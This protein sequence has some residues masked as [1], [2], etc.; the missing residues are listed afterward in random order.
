MLNAIE[1]SRAT[2]K[3]EQ[4][5]QD[6]RP[7]ARVVV[8]GAN[9]ERDRRAYAGLTGTLVRPARWVACD[10]WL[11]VLDDSHAEIAR[12]TGLEERW[13]WAR[14]TETGHTEFPESELTVIAE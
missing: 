14:V 7:G 13:V 9:A 3:A 2:A 1:A 11:L 6:F 12:A 10:A 5:N 4:T 8:N